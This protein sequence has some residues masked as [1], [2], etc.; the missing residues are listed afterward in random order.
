MSL[1]ARNAFCVV[2]GLTASAFLFLEFA[3]R[4]ERQMTALFVVMVAA[5]VGNALITGGLS[6]V[7]GRY[8]SRIV[9]LVVFYAALGG[10][11]LYLCGTRE[12]QRRDA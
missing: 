1:P 6:G 4:G 9:W 10:H 7:H 5:L 8:Q 11:Y 3:R 2:V 12:E